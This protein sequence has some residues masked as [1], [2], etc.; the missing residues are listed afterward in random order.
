MLDYI[1]LFLIV[2]IFT[3]LIIDSIFIIKLR[4][5]VQEIDSKIVNDNSLL[6][7]SEFNK[8]D[9]EF[10]KHYKTYVVNGI[11]P[12]VVN[13]INT[14]IKKNNINQ[15]IEK[16]KNE[17]NEFIKVFSNELNTN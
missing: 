2:I 1:N 10:K 11:M 4:K 6:D 16:N 7:L 3:V 15:E 12:P 5:R 14:E 8:L 9:P 13:A 17:I